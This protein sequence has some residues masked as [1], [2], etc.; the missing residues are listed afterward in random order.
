M[1]HFHAGNTGSFPFW[2]TECFWLFVLKVSEPGG[3]GSPWRLPSCL[4]SCGN[5]KQNFSLILV[6][7][8]LFMVQNIH[9]PRQS[10]AK[11]N[12]KAV[13]SV[14][15]TSEREIPQLKGTK[16]SDVDFLFVWPAGRTPSHVMNSFPVL[17]DHHFHSYWFGSD[18]LER[19]AGGFRSE[20]GSVRV[21]IHSWTSV[22][23]RL[24]TFLHISS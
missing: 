23:C 24:Q 15:K 20:L 11:S 16:L 13:R 12:W 22:T 21:W 14:G 6:I 4:P 17:L 8:N 19:W 2:F 7:Q 1:E 10:A 5:N 3:D 18:M 9:S